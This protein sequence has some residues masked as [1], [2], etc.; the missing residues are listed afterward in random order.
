MFTTTSP[1]PVPARHRKLRKDTHSCWECKRRKMR[2]VFEPAVNPSVCYGCLRRG[3][4]CI[5]QDSSDGAQRTISTTPRRV[6]PH[7]ERNAGSIDYGF[8]P[9]LQ[10]TEKSL[11]PISMASETLRHGPPNSSGS[12]SKLLHNA[13]PSGEDTER[14]FAAIPSLHTVPHEIMT[15]PYTSLAPGQPVSRPERKVPAASAH[16][17]LLAR[18]MLFIAGLLQHLHPDA[19]P[20]LKE[21]AEMPQVMSVRLAD[22]AITHVTTEDKL[23]GSI[24]GLTCIIME[25]VYHANAGNLRRS[26]MTARRAITVAQLM[27]LSSH[28]RMQLEVLENGANYDTRVIWSRMVFLDRFLCLLLGLPQACNDRNMDFEVISKTDLQLARLEQVHCMVASGIID[29][30]SHRSCAEGAANISTLDLELQK[31]ARDVPKRWWL[32]PEFT[33]LDAEGSSRIWETGR[34]FAQVLHYNLLNQLHLPH[35]LQHKTEKSNDY[36]LVTCVSAS[37]EILT[38]FLA[39][40]SFNGFMPSCRIIDFIALM[41]AM[42]L[43]L[44]HLDCQH[45]GTRNLLAHQYHSDRA[46]V[47]QVQ[48]SYQQAGSGFRSDPV[49]TQSADLLDK[50]LAVDLASFG[51]ATG[52]VTLHRLETATN[53]ETIKGVVRVPIP[54]FGMIQIARQNN[55]EEPTRVE[56]STLFPTTSCHNDV[57]P[58]AEKTAANDPSPVAFGGAQI[59]MPSFD[60][61]DEDQGDATLDSPEMLVGALYEDFPGLA[62]DTSDW[63][64]QGVDLAYFDNLTMY[65]GNMSVQ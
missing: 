11:T 23:L 42:T 54:Y 20:A 1:L 60:M 65:Q 26:W 63:A 21:L 37:R 27:G 5:G 61:V 12:L 43:L 13:L 30:S 6:G 50:L 32:I 52:R 8:S 7:H 2:C 22:L 53:E 59:A 28:A 3:S 49:S 58:P 41:A 17:V 36:A 18:H 16:P 62:A 55:I 46:L 10:S 25:S 15:M 35:M 14:I 40:R 34:L 64:L 31:A 4:A 45:L 47:E 44:A 19:Q 38:R 48:E 29:R 24:E 57:T 9:A 33:K 39:L 56:N 51:H